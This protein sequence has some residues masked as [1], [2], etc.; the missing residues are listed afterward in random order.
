MD[1]TWEQYVNGMYH[2]QHK[3]SEQTYEYGEVWMTKE[4]KWNIFHT[5]DD[6]YSIY[7]IKFCPFCGIKLE[8]EL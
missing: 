6:Y 8:I 7:D 4:G 1:E 5:W 2:V 3:C